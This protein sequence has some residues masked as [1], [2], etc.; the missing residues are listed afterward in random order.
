MTLRGYAQNKHCKLLLWKQ[1]YIKMHKTNWCSSRNSY[2]KLQAAVIV[3][4][5]SYCIWLL[6]YKSAYYK[7]RLLW[8]N[9]ML[10][11]KIKWKEIERDLLDSAILLALP[12]I[13]IDLSI[14]KSTK[15]QKLLQC[16][17]FNTWFFSTEDMVM[18]ALKA[19]VFSFENRFSA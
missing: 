1:G 11:S 12:N 13:L 5:N 14:I 7:F 15:G 9:L 3:K 19:N 4:K 2:R 8:P 10:I 16:H 18:Q 17:I 6:P